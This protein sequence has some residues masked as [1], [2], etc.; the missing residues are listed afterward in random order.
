MSFRLSD[1]SILALTPEECER[2]YDDLWSE[3]LRPG[4]VSAAAKLRHANRIRV[5]LQ[6]LDERE[7]AAL[8]YVVARLRERAD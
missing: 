1:G 4:A 7:T 6:D 3:G 8:I 5:D 2:A